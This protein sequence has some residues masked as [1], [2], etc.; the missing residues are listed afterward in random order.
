MARSPQIL[1]HRWALQQ[2]ILK[3]PFSSLVEDNKCTKVRLEIMLTESSH[4]G[5]HFVNQEGANTNRGDLQT[6]VA[7]QHKDIASQVQQG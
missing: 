4:S 7:F 2:G 6:K 5:P 3:L 1:L